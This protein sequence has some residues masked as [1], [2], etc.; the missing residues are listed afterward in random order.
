MSKA[1]LEQWLQRLERLHP[2]AVDLGLE[3]VSAVARAG[4]AAA[5]QP[6]VTVAGTNG[7]GST[8]AVLEALLARA[9]KSTGSFTSPHFLRFNERIRW[10][11]SKSGCGDHRGVCAIEEARGDISLTYFE[12][13]ALAA[14]LIFGQRSRISLFWRWAGWS[15]GCGQHCRYR[16][17]SYYQHRS[18]SPGM[19]GRGPGEIGVEKAGIVR[20]GRPV[21]IADAD[22]PQELLDTWMEWVRRRCC[23]WV[24]HLP[25][26]ESRGPQGACSWRRADTACWHC[27]R[28]GRCCQRTSVPRCRRRAAGYRLQRACLCMRLLSGSAVT[29]RRE[30]RQVAGVDY[31]L[32]VAHNPASVINWLNK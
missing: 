4:A 3:R 15:S 5:Q 23:A 22:P 1:S 2:S 9:G 32:D 17:R 29:A 19:A 26:R 28:A 24:R 8:V 13:A 25:C 21:V 16:H 31:V 14:L 11:V 18:G 12:F 20:Q 30:A 27:L 6:V 7:K 10:R